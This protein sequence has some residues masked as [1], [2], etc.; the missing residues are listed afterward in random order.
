MT[1][2]TI[3]DGLR[4]LG[5]IYGTI[6]EVICLPSNQVCPSEQKKMLEG[7]ECTPV[8]LDL[9]SAMLEDFTELKATI[10]DL[11]VALRKGADATLSIKIQL[12]TSLVKKGTIHFKK[13]TKKI[14]SD[15]EDYRMVKQ[16]SE[17]SEITTSLLESTLYLLSKQL[18]MPK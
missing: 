14:T 15:K 1:I 12:F 16:L 13:T 7:T 2:E 18:V 8:L 3:S 11:Q 9:C 17:A 5:D 4:R 6:E 10:Q